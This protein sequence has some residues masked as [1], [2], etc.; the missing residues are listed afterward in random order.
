MQE[1]REYDK[2]KVAEE[3]DHECKGVGS[4]DAMLSVRSESVCRYRAGG[5]Q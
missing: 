3:G 4:D 1:E 2:A 5:I